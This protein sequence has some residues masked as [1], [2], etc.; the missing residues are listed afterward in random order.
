VSYVPEQM[1]VD[2]VEALAQAV[3]R[4]FAKLSSELELGVATRVDRFLPAAPTKLRD[5]MIVG[6]DG[7]NWNPGSGKGAYIYYG[8]AWHFLG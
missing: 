1:P 8:A 4:E 3:T 5:G 6:A 2:S 7:T